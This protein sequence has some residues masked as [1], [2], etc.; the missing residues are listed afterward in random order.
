MWCGAGSEAGLGDVYA[1]GGEGPGTGLLSPFISFASESPFPLVLLERR[2]IA[3]SGVGGR[4]GEP[5]SR[6][7]NT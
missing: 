7:Y 5:S 1:S 2:E 6:L 4:L 3:C